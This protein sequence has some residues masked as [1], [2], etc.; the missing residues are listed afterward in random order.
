MDGSNAM[1]Q[2]VSFLATLGHFCAFL[3]TKEPLGMQR[4]LFS[5]IREYYIPPYKVV[6]PCKLLEK[7]NG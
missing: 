2:K 7:Y 1:R 6:T 5:K 4:E 3:A